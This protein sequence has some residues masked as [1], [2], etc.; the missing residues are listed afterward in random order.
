MR[1]VTSL[2][3]SLLLIASQGK[4]ATPAAAATAS[5]RKANP[6]CVIAA[7]LGAGAAITPRLIYFL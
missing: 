5:L 4:Y 6:D 2:L 7:H 3:L 1:F